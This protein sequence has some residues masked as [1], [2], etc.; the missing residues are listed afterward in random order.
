MGRCLSPWYRA[1]RGSDWP[2]QKAPEEELLLEGGLGL[3]RSADLL[4]RSGL[5][6]SLA[7]IPVKDQKSCGIYTARARL[8]TLCTL[9]EMDLYP[10][11]YGIRFRVDVEIMRGHDFRG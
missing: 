10:N 6:V 4:K 7:H 1:E 5:P 8:P 2:R 9:G 11:A 3:A